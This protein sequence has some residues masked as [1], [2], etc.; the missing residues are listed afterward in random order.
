M[1]TFAETLQYSEQHCRT[2]KLKCFVVNIS[3]KNELSNTAAMVR[4]PAEI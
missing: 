2:N 1:K 3:V 4:D